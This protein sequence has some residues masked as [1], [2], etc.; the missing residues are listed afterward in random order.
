M[1]LC[2]ARNRS[3]GTCRKTAGWGTQHPGVGRCRLHGGASPHAEISGQVELARREIRLLEREIPLHPHDAIE[4]CIRIMAGQLMTANEKVA[5]LHPDEWIGHKDGV[6]PWVRL[7]AEYADRLMGYAAAAAKAG[8]DE[9]RTQL[10]ELHGQRI[11]EVF[12]RVFADLGIDSSSPEVRESVR[13]QLTLV[14]GEG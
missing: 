2:G 14:A 6:N 10:A 3:N 5:D 11:A 8:I 1:E 13:R 7:Q 4:W 12:S 9:R